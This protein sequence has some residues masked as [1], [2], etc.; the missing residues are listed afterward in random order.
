[1]S[2]LPNRQGNKQTVRWGC[3]LGGSVLTHMVNGRDWDL[4]RQVS[5]Q[6]RPWRNQ[7]MDAACACTYSTCMRVRVCV[8]VCS[9]WWLEPSLVWQRSA[10]SNCTNHGN[11]SGL[12]RRAKH[13]EGHKLLFLLQKYGSG[14]LW[15]SCTH[16]TLEN[17]SAERFSS[18]TRLLEGEESDAVRAL[19]G[20]T[21][22][23]SSAYGVRES[24]SPSNISAKEFKNE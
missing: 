21:N 8:C 12:K 17:F 1:M 7:D 19:Q 13:G 10:G 14:W 20:E 2:L 6:Q 5:S 16:I 3:G 4:R 23:A 24:T 22:R 11:S 15:V 9:R 18:S